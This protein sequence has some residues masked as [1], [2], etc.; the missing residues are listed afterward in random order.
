VTAP[1]L[2]RVKI[3][4]DDPDLP[5]DPG[6]AIDVGG[7]D[8]T[9]EFWLR[10]SAADNPAPAVTCGS[11]I[12]WIYGNIV[13]DRDRYN[14]DRKYGVSIAGGAVVF[15]VSGD[16][17]G[18][19][20]LCSATSVLDAAW[21]HVAL[22][23]RRSDGRLWLYVDGSLEAEVDGP[24]GDV[25]YPNDG[26][27]GEYCGGPCTN[28]DPFIVLGAEKHDAGASFPSYAGLLDELRYSDSL[29]YGGA[30]FAPP[31]APFVAD[32]NTV[33]LYH[34][35]QSGACTGSVV[36]GSANA[37]D[38]DCRFGGSPPSGPVFDADDPFAAAAVPASSPH[39]LALGIGASGCLAAAWASRRA[40]RR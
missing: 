34:F 16:G 22:E 5:D 28:S 3:R 21:H 19:A 33:A 27:P 36:D 31:A 8:F 25:S 20:T 12:D 29:R 14:Q 35:D 6:P 37:T 30:S 15:G 23:R 2:D 9:I 11:N 24:D 40:R 13:I 10:A 32:A 18:D 17:T 38:G 26:V 4:I 39:W 1:D 7:G